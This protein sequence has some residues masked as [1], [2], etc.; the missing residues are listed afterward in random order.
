MTEVGS[1]LERDGF[2]L[3]WSVEPDGGITLKI[4]AGEADCADC[5]V[6]EPVL[7]AIVSKALGS[8]DYYVKRLDLPRV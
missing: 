6:P 7:R 2:T 8:S 1:L 5:L 3:D 4:G